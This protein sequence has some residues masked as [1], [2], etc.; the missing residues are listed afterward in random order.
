MLTKQFPAVLLKENGD[1]LLVKSKTGSGAKAQTTNGTNEVVKEFKKPVEST[2]ESQHGYKL[3]N[4]SVK[5]EF[6]CNRADL[7]SALF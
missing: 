2:Q 7:V 6:K 1:N 4:V 5:S 3:S